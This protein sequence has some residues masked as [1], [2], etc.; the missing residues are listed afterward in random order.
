MAQFVAA[1]EADYE[2][3]LRGMM[4]GMAGA[5]PKLAKWITDQ[6]LKTN[7]KVAVGLIR[8]VQNLK[9]PELFKAAGVPIRCV[10][11]APR[12]GRG[13]ATNIEGNRQYADF[14]A[15]LM[16]DVGHFLMME[17]PEAFNEKL[18]LVLAELR[19]G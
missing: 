1:F 3:T 10:N 6:A 19:V 13:Y 12:E 9:M 17:E 5:Q 14:D 16:E 11:A 18:E 8:D 2:G 7:E 15:V 4:A